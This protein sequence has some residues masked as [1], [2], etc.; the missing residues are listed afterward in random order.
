MASLSSVSSGSNTVSSLM[1]SANMISGLA[2]GLDTESMIESLVQS[3]STKINQ[4][5]QKVTKVEWKQDAYRSI[6]SKMVGFSN[7]YTSYTSS[8]NL[9]SSSFFSS[10]IKVLAKG[11]FADSVNASGKTGSDVQLNAVR[12]LAASAQYRTKSNL[13]TTEAGVIAASDGVDLSVDAERDIELSNL[14]GSLTLTYG[15]KN[16]SISFN[17]STDVDTMKDIRARLSSEQGISEESVSDSEV[18]AELI[19]QKLADQ[20]IAFTNGNSESANQRIQATAYGGSLR[21]SEI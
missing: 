15:T 10:A 4:L 13:P 21:V 9:M 2:S 18:L 5:N 20:N 16:V 11:A 19:N 3:Y 14:Q 17:E 1:N 6:I 8:T 12:Q 7:K